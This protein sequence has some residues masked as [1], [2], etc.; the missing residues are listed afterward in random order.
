MQIENL[1][2]E[3]W[4]SN[5][6]GFLAYFAITFPDIYGLGD[7]IH[8]A[9]ANIK[10]DVRRVGLLHTTLEEVGE[11]EKLGSELTGRLLH[12]LNYKAG[13][14]STPQIR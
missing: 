11:G 7:R 13:M 4:T 3:S 10:G 2:S 1:L 8:I 12:V 9:N 14:G 6:A 5:L